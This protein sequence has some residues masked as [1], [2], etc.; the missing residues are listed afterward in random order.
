[1]NEFYLFKM[2][3]TLLSTLLC[4]FLGMIFHT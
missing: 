4:K 2:H 1:M 3:K